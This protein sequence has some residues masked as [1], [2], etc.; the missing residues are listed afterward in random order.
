MNKSFVITAAL[1]VATAVLYV[2]ASAPFNQFYLG[3]I[4]LVPWLVA[5]E[6][7]SS[8]RRGF[9]AGWLGGLIV[10]AVH[11]ISVTR[12]TIAG[13]AALCAALALAWGIA[14]WAARSL[15]R[16]ET[17]SWKSALAKSAAFAL[18]WTACEWLRGRLLLDYPIYLLGHTQAS[19]LPV[20]QIA[21]LAGAYGVTFLLAGIN[22]CIAQ[23]L[24]ARGSVKLGVAIAAPWTITLLLAIGYGIFRLSQHPTTPGP[25]IMVVQSNNPFRRGG[26]PGIDQKEHFQLLLKLTQDAL[27]ST[28][29]NNEVM[30]DLVVWPESITPPINEEARRELEHFEAG[31]LLA[32]TFTALSHLALIEKTSLIVGGYSVNNWKV[33][34]GK[35]T[36]TDIRNSAYLFDRN[37]DLVDR[38]DKIHLV[39]FGEYLPFHTAMLQWLA[40]RPLDVMLHPGD[41]KQSRLRLD[42]KYELLPAICLEDNVAEEMLSRA[43]APK[44][45]VI[46]SLNNDGW[47]RSEF[48]A[49]RLAAA[50]F[51]CIENRLP[52]ARSENGGISAFIDSSG[53]VSDKIPAWQNGTR[54]QQMMLD[55]RT[56]LYEK[57]GDILPPIGLVVLFGLLIRSWIIR[58]PRATD[59]NDAEEASH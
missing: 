44:P 42:G 52:M 51:I 39:P 28:H 27:A 30:P 7:T 6:R 4:C 41:L 36:G 37:G 38:Y 8:P 18:I 23:L 3:L 57:T 35:R 32:E 56:T 25:R 1:L 54:V 45:D 19:F 47:F 46:I 26:E 9:T 21:D 59:A 53:G 43:S 34:A 33:V 17:V 2:L 5:M 14:G 24:L 40:P 29:A 16:D 49:Q 31:P 12:L 20:A 58:L 22:A 13:G 55:P 11:L 50:Q 48:M 15:F 10:F